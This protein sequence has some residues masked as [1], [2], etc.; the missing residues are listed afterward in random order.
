[1]ADPKIVFY[2]TKFPATAKVRS[3]S[4]WIR[5]LLDV[6]N[7]LYEEVRNAFFGKKFLFF[8]YL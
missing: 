4:N 3:D 6:K 1:M 2:T 8:F 5:Y 7:V